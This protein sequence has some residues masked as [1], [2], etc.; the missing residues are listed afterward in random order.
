MAVAAASLGLVLAQ[1]AQ[2]AE[3]PT[4][5]NPAS[6]CQ[7]P[8]SPFKGA[9]LDG[10]KAEMRINFPAHPCPI[11]VWVLRLDEERLGRRYSGGEFFLYDPV[12]K[13]KFGGFLSG[14]IMTSTVSRPEYVSVSQDNVLPAGRTEV[15]YG[16]PGHPAVARVV[17]TVTRG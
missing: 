9:K 11:Y 12:N 15:R 6:A 7:T 5:A 10:F 2:A 13:E 8:A 3:A 14:D 16:N 17:A 4:P 1:G